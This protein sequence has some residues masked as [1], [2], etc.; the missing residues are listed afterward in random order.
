LAFFAVKNIFTKA[1]NDKCGDVKFTAKAQSFSQSSLRPFVFF[2]LSS[3]AFFAVKIF[4]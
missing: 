4:L 1:E 3:L 2:A